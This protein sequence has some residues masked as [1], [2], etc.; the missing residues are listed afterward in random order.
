MIDLKLLDDFTRRVSAAIPAGARE[1]QDDLE[2]NIRVALSAAFARLDLVT[3]EE[4]D[5]QRALLERTRIKLEELDRRL[6]AL[7]GDRQSGL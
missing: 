2:K 7:E 3:R 4:F 1:L 6:A 5:V